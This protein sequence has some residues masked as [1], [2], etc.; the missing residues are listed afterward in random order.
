MCQLGFPQ[1]SIVCIFIL[2]IESKVYTASVYLLNPADKAKL[3][4]I[5][6]SPPP[7]SPHLGNAVDCKLCYSAL[8][9]N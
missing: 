3:K 1:H 2:A 6:I 9:D 7:S 4:I 8:R 5:L